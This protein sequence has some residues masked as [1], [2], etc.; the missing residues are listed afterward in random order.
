MPNNVDGTMPNNSESDIQLNGTTDEA[1]HIWQALDGIASITVNSPGKQI[2]ASVPGNN[3]LPPSLSCPGNPP[4][5]DCAILFTF[6]QPELVTVTLSARA[7]AFPLA[8]VH[9]SATVTAQADFR[10]IAYVATSLKDYSPFPGASISLTA[11]PEPSTLA[12]VF[13]SLAGVAW[14]RLRLVPAKR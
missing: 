2:G 12:I 8:P 11:V 7:L 13:L 6:G 1:P 10:G 14:S 5:S 4:N 3:N 9:P